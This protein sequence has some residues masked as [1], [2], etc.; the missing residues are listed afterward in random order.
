MSRRAAAPAGRLLWLLILACVAAAHAHVI[1]T[2]EEALDEAFP[3][4][5]VRRRTAFLDEEQVKRI[6]ELAAS[7]LRT[8]VVTFYEGQRDGAILGTAYFDSHVVRTL[9]E[10]IMVLV[11]PDGSLGRVSILSFQEPRDYLPSDRWLDQFEGEGLDEALTLKRDI[12]GITGATLSARAI[13]RSVRRMLAIHRVLEEA[14]GS[15]PEEDDGP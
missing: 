11:G 13:T 12:R 10:V 2:Q 9:P 1:Q 7:E 3:E 4:A 6:E 8:R 14:D 5:E 15:E